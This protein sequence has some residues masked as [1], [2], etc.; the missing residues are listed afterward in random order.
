MKQNKAYKVFNYNKSLISERK[1]IELFG[2]LKLS[3]YN[4]IFLQYINCTRC[5]YN[6][7]IN[8]LL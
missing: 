5:T 3:I 6:I 2:L 8:N 7:Y 1:N 4:M